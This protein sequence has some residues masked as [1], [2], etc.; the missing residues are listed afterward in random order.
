[1]IC[2]SVNLV[3]FMSVILQRLTGFVPFKWYGLEGAG[4]WNGST[5]LCAINRCHSITGPICRKFRCSPL[6]GYG[7]T[8]TTAQIWPWAAS[9][10]SS[11]WPRLH[12]RSTSHVSGKQVDYHRNYRPELLFVF[13]C[14]NQPLLIQIII[15]IFWGEFSFRPKIKA[16]T[17][18][19]IFTRI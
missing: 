3:F 19:V 14:I 6:S 18:P 2:S 1:M 10:Q 9:H 4:Q 16:N 8:I 15:H 13:Q 5:G 12:N 17:T 11:D 7:N